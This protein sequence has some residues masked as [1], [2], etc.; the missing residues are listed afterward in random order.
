M[1]PLITFA[2]AVLGVSVLAQEPVLTDEILRRLGGD[3]EARRA[4]IAKRAA[5]E[6]NSADR[7]L[8]EQAKEMAKN[9][10]DPAALIALQSED[11]LLLE[12]YAYRMYEAYGKPPPWALIVDIDIRQRPA[13]AKLMG[14]LIRKYDRPGLRYGVLSWLLTHPDVV[15][16]KAVMEEAVRDCLADPTKWD[17]EERYCLQSAVAAFG[18]DSHDAVFDQLEKAGV[19]IGSDR[20]KLKARLR[21]ETEKNARSSM[22]GALPG[23]S[24]KAQE[25]PLR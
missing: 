25:R 6:M 1:K 2:L 3:P 21:L 11:P 7:L 4:A 12:V 24:Q 18:D 15:W 19:A 9:L 10:K 5:E 13:A 20:M 17:H 8:T 16:N 22:D 23:Q 14:E